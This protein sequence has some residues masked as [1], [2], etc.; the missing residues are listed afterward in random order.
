[1]KFLAKPAKNV[2]HSTRQELTKL[3]SWFNGSFSQ[4]TVDA[5]VRGHPRE[6]EE[7]SAAG[8]GRL[9]ECVNLQSLGARVQ[10]VFCQGDRK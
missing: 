2:Y 6:A 1:M 10:T 8:A 4:S 7:V 5:P 9:R 3:T